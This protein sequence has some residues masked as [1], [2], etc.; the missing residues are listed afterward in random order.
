MLSPILDQPLGL[1]QWI[2][3]IPV[4]RLV[5]DGLCGSTGLVRPEEHF[6]FG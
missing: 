1:D 2:A 6:G 5:K 3:E 4:E